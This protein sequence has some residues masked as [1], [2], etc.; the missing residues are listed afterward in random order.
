MYMTLKYL[1][2]HVPKC[3]G[4][5][6]ET[7]FKSFGHLSILE[8]KKKLKISKFYTFS[9]VRNPYDRFI[10]AYFYLKDN[11]A[12]DKMNTQLKKEIDKINSV[13]EMINKLYDHFKTKKIHFSRVTENSLINII[14]FRPMYT[15]TCNKNKEIIIDKIIYFENMNDEINLLLK[16][17]NKNTKF[18]KTNNS[19]RIND[20]KYYFDNLS[21]E[22]IN[23]FHKIYYDDFNVFNY[24]FEY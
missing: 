6:L 11:G 17:N 20:Y 4:T 5:Q 15:F 8:I 21:E 19:K 9:I 14:H 13:E 22:V 12:F 2:I 18:I 23:K 16:K 10:S 24:S 1:F 7:L 3:A